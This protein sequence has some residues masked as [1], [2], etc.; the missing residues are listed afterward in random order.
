M[1]GFFK[2]FVLFALPRRVLNI[3]FEFVGFEVNK[4]SLWRGGIKGHGEKGFIHE[5]IEN[6]TEVVKR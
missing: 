4:S 6:Q 2:S 5:N 1:H 3:V